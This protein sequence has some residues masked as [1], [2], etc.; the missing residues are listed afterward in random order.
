MARILITEDLGEL[1]IHGG[2]RLA[3][4]TALASAGFE[5]EF[6]DTAD[7]ATYPEVHAIFVNAPKIGSDELDR[8]P[9]LELIVRFGSGLD[10]IDS[11]E[12]DR[13]NIT[14]RNI[15][16]PI[17]AE[18]TGAI[19]GIILDRLFQLRDKEHAFQL[20][21]WDSRQ[22]IAAVGTSATVGLVGAG[23]IA[24]RLAPVLGALG[25]RVCFASESVSQNDGGSIGEKLPLD[26]LCATSDVVV[27]LSPLRESTRGLIDAARL[28]RMK[29]QSHLIVMSRGGVVDERAALSAL[30]GKRIASLHLDVFDGEPV[31]PE[32][33]MN[34]PGL[35]VTPHNAAWSDTFF[36]ETLREATRIF[37]ENFGRS[38]HTP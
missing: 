29:K 10:N 5:P 19:T 4:R 22:T 14:V 25:L 11:R 2:W 30:E 37:C 36:H 32:P 17:A 16:D 8:L 28:R 15:P 9:A 12:C 26:E 1:D 38:R 24:A 13:R 20:E 6:W 21:G 33:Y 18:M 3:I 31:I 7:E 23:R 27:V 35:T 34:I